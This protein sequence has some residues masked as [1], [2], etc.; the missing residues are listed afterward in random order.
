VS[1]EWNGRERR[2][3]DDSLAE[4]MDGHWRLDDERWVAHREKH[5]D[6]AQSLSEYKGAANE[7]R[8]TLT[9][10]R[11]TMLSRTEYAA[12]HKALSSTITGDV[13]RLEARVVAVER[14]MQTIT[15]RQQVTRDN[16]T[17]IRNVIVFGFTILGSLVGLAIY[18]RA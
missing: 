8:A 3:N 15:D 12:E 14:L 4:R 1:A 16:F 13:D 17:A 2:S 11:G 9:D 6:L 5:T 10:V 18:L 7:W